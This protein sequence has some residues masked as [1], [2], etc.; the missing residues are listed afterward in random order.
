ML[1]IVDVDLN[2]KHFFIRVWE[3]C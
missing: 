2:S 1:N 3:T